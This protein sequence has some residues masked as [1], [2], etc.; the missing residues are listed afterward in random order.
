M[1]QIE[2]EEGILMTLEHSKAH[3]VFVIKR[4]FENFS[5][6]L[7]CEDIKSPECWGDYRLFGTE[8][9]FREW[10]TKLARQTLKE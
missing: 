4:Q 3:I 1:I 7:N 10:I 8:D 9:E 6:F 5:D 2:T